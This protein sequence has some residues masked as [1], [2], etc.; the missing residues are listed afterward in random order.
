MF[1]EW[2][3]LI[4]ILSPTKSILGF[5]TTDMSIVCDWLPAAFYKL[6]FNSSF[7]DDINGKKHLVS[8]QM[9]RDKLN[10]KIM[11]LWYQCI[12]LDN[13]ATWIKL[14]CN[15]RWKSKCRSQVWRTRSAFQ[16]W[17][18]FHSSRD[19]SRNSKSQ[20]AT[21]EEASYFLLIITVSQFL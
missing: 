3:S 8:H 20:P 4:Q 6:E 7:I 1:Y 16:N 10:L 5:K 14:Y 18:C 13:S 2:N 15:I 12:Q 9:W 21:T 19:F 11:Q 17:H